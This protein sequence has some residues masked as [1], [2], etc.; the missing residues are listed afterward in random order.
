MENAVPKSAPGRRLWWLIAAAV[1][2]WWTLNGLAVGLQWMLMVDANG[3][4]VSAW[5]ALPASLAGAWGW[6]PLSL[7]LVWLAFRHPIDRGQVGRGLALHGAAVAAIVLVRAL[8]IYALDP[9]LHWYD[10]APAFSEVLIQ[11]VWNNLF[12]GTLFVGVAH[13]LVFAARARERE[14]LAAQLQAQLAD[15]RLAA[16]SSQLNP[17]FLFNALNSIAE[18]VHR[19]PVAADGMIVG[20]AALLRSSLETGRNPEVPLEEELRLLGYYLDIERI[21]L[22]E[23]LRVEWA[24]AP[25]ARAALVPPLLLQ[26]L[27]ENAVRHGI[28]LRM[29]PGTICVRAQRDGEMLRLEIRDDGAGG[30]AGGSGFGIG[31]ATTRQRLEA[32]YGAAGQ[33]QLLP[34]P[35]GGMV[36]QL[37]LP[38]RQLRQAA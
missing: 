20:L 28:S 10:T 37:S 8:Y 16:L 23:R 7:G 31:L 15:A 12:Q 1:F 4:G 21:R 3:V 13:A 17:H 38:F 22:G 30:G 24:V 26:P 14:R 2:A 36:A 11:S 32:L 18:L 19:D 29:S 35:E 6:A 25:E 27:V 9:W 34:A 33:L 5:R